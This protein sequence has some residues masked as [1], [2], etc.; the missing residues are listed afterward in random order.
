MQ[1]VSLVVRVECQK[2]YGRGL[3]SDLNGVRC[4]IRCRVD[5]CGGG[6]WMPL[7][8]KR[9]DRRRDPV[10]VWFSTYI[11]VDV[12]MA[13]KVVNVVF[14]GGECGIQGSGCDLW[15]CAVTYLQW[16]YL[17]GE[18][19]GNRVVELW[20]PVRIEQDFCVGCFGAR[21][22]A[23]SVCLLVVSVEESVR[24]SVLST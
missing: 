23:V 4:G 6:F 2:E 17:L 5:G 19:G 20:W 12:L 11:E 22:I 8:K 18:T 10:L 14:V 7:C 16:G 13:R 15:Q 3:R 9:D 1:G 21:D 24:M